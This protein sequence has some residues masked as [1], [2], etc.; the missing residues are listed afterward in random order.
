MKFNKKLLAGGMLAASLLA[1]SA[2]AKVSPAEAAKLGNQLTPIGAEK[3]ASADGKIPAW[4]G[5]LKKIPAGFDGSTY[6]NPF[7]NEKPEFVIDQSNYQKYQDH[8]T[9]GQ[10][11]MIKRYKDYRIRVFP[12]HRT[13]A[14]PEKIY[15]D[16]KKNATSAELAKGGNGL[17]DFTGAVPFPIPQNGLQA[18]WNHITRYRGGSVEINVAQVTP[19]ANGDF[20]PVQFHEYLTMR[21]ALT[22]YKPDVDPN[23]LFYFEQAITAPS[24]LAG[25]VLLVHEPINQVKEPRRAWI[26]N[27][28]QRRVRRAPQ[29]AYDG[30]GT[31]S[32]GLRTSDDFDM[33]NGSPDRYNWKLL[34]K[35]EIYVPYNNYQLM[36]KKY[37]YKDIIKPGHINSDLARYEMH[38]VWVVEADLKP[39][40][41]HIYAKRVFYIDEDSWGVTIA[42][43]YDG[44]GNL[45]RVSVG[46]NTY[47]YDVKVPWYAFQA[48]YDLQSGRY[49]AMGLTNEQDNAYKFG[50]KRSSADYTPAALRR[51]GT[52]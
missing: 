23:I 9:P 45:W 30:P 31:A 24:R 29:V 25:N 21:T 12:S 10:I 14:F 11:A 18:I 32:D 46:Y 26:Y 13:A 6:I 38:R 27:A 36:S 47:F 43:E 52:R 15:Q 28:G 16:A 51:A 4:D 7:P 2:W 50:V 39:G 8:L 3:A 41:R 33:Y 40:K 37:S 34:G 22:D 35:K 49:I 44:R 48:I 19:L 17:K 42:D 20:T 1:G 5:G